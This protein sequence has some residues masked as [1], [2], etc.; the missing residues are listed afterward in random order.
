LEEYI[1]QDISFW[2][3]WWQNKTPESEIQMWDFYAGRH[4][5][6]KYVPRNGIVLELGCGFGRYNFILDKMGITN[7]GIDFDG[8]LIEYLE[9]WKL[10][11]NLNPKFKQGNILKLPYNDN[12]ISGCISLGVVEHFIEGPHKAIS[13][14][15][16]ILRPGG[17]AIIST[18][19]ITLH[20]FYFHIKK[21][22]RNLFKK[23]LHIKLIDSP[24]FQYWYRPRKLVKYIKDAGFKVTQ[25]R[26]IDL[27]SSFFMLGKETGKN[28]YNGS[29]A[30]KLANFF[31]N[32]FISNIGAQSF[33]IA[34]KEAEKMHCFFC[35]ELLATRSS[36]QTYV[37][38]ICMNCINEPLIKFYK[39]G[40]YPFFDLPYIINPPLL[41]PETRECFYCN[42]E[43]VTDEIFEDFGFSRNV[44]SD[45]LRNK[46]INIELAIKY[47]KPI[48]RKRT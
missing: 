6:L 39:E 16:R 23:Y 7:E 13:E 30:V 27:L 1:G 19:S 26:G 47:V 8:E 14:M 32:T 9:L 18:P 24:F 25:F 36:L 35:G 10:R 46:K 21:F 12:S 4:W 3:K 31:E 37:V 29:F 28:I 38:P 43:Y 11:Y 41:K 48:W 15:Y 42:K 45:C 33:T 34:V 5:V 17:I 44:C 22:I 2:H 40:C 20:N